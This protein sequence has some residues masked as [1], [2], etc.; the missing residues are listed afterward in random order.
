MSYGQEGKGNPDGLY[1]QLSV[2]ASSIAVNLALPI[3]ILELILEET[4]VEGTPTMM[5]DYCNKI[6]SFLIFL[7]VL[8]IFLAVFISIVRV[9]LRYSS[10]S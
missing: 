4:K 2:A 8:W 1:D 3:Y 7:L 10:I 9:Y 5:L 6:Y